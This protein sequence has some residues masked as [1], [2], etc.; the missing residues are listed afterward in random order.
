MTSDARRFEFRC[1]PTLS[2]GLRRKIEIRYD[3]RTEET[4]TDTYFLI[5]GR[6]DLLVKLRGMVQLDVKACLGWQGP[7]ELWHRALETR[8]PLSEAGREA[9][10]RLSPGLS[11]SSAGMVSP[12]EAILQLGQAGPPRAISKSR[13][14]STVSGLQVELTSVTDRCVTRWTLAY[15][16]P[17]ADRLTAELNALSLSQMDN[18]NYGAALR[19]PEIFGT[20]PG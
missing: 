6:N 4:R 8:F 2:R 16:C 14:L 15:E 11:R 10:S 7:L 19:H 3:F 20:L 9:L 1:W 13:R 5:P 12:A 18:L 17:D